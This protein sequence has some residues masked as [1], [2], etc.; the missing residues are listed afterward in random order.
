MQVAA[1]VGRQQVVQV[2]R[3][4]RV[5]QAQAAGAVARRQAL[6]APARVRRDLVQ[7]E[8]EL[9][10][11]GAAW[12]PRRGP[13]ARHADRD[14]CCRATPLTLWLT[15]PS[16]SRS[17]STAVT[18]AMASAVLMSG[19]RWRRARYSSSDIGGLRGRPARGAAA[20][21]SC[22]A[23]TSMRPMWTW[24]SVG[25]AVDARRRCDAAAVLGRA[26]RPARTR[27][28]AAGPKRVAA[29]TRQRAVGGGASR[30]RAVRAA[31]GRHRWQLARSRR[32]GLARA[33]L[34]R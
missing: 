12:P 33:D 6:V 13:A 10:G 29:G 30:A 22:T 24:T 15:S 26:P 4:R 1:A 25:L 3:E 8:V 28:A 31:A 5:G 34:R 20:A 23:V 27:T 19:L 32:R 11:L 17:R 18:P 21:A 14:A 9:R 7:E 2:E 16:L